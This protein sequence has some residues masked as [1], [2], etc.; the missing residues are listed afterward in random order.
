MHSCIICNMRGCCRRLSA[1]DLLKDLNQ[2][3]QNKVKIPRILMGNKEEIETLINEEALLFAM[4]LRR[5]KSSW[6]PRI[7]S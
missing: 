2:N 5:E 3:F 1:R 6:I 4:Y 7:L